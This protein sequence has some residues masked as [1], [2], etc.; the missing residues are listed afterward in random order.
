MAGPSIQIGMVIGFG[1]DWL[2]LKQSLLYLR[3]DACSSSGL[4]YWPP[5]VYKSTPSRTRS[6]L[7]Y[8]PGGANSR[9]TPQLRSDADI[10]KGDQDR[11][12]GSSGQKV[13]RST[14][15]SSGQKVPRSTDGSSSQKISVI[16]FTNWF[17]RAIDTSDR[18]D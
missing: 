15:G 8:W 7:E 11:L 12:D 5:D 3:N 18:D 6:P 14:D 2:T 1:F 17:G 16:K 13:P 9:H 4:E 10:E